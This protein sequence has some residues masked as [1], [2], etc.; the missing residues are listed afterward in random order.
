MTNAVATIGLTFASTDLQAADFGI[1]L[2]IV[3][4]LNERPLPRGV[5][6]T[7][8]G[9]AGRIVRNRKADVLV[10]ELRGHVLGTGAATTGAE[11][12]GGA[13]TTLS[14]DTIAGAFTVTVA[15]A[16]SI[17]DGDYL[18]VGDAGE[19]EIRQVATGGVSGTTITLT[20]ALGRAHDAGDQVREV[21]SSGASGANG[22]FR[23]NVLTVR[24]LFDP[25]A[26]PASLV[27]VLENGQTASI[28]ARTINSLWD[29]QDPYAAAVSI[30]LEAVTPDWTIA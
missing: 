13:N 23:A 28:T 29:Q 21:D 10:I 30:E 14:A 8:P 5:D 16:T 22:I 20:A 26:E 7:V 17:A 2:E 12:V 11:T 24:T 15:S 19:T 6:L 25:S 1:F 18:R 9:R 4:G 3:R 27:A